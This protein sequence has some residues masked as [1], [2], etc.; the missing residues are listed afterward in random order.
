MKIRRYPPNIFAKNINLA[1]LVDIED[2]EVCQTGIKYPLGSGPRTFT[3]DDLADAV[4]S[5]DDSAVKTPRIKLGH[6][7]GL[8]IMEDGQPAIGTV[9]DM[10]TEQGGHMLMG[11]L[12]Q[13]PEWLS[14]ILP[15]AY[16]ARS[17]EGANEVE[18][19]T[20]NKWRLVITD[21][22][23]L[24]VVWPGVTT[25]ED[26]QALYSKDGPDNVRV[27]T[28]KEEVASLSVAAAAAV[29]AQVNVDD[30]AREWG[31]HK[32]E[33]NNMMW[34]W[35]RAMLMDPNELIV[36]DEDEGELYRIPYTISGEDVAF[37]DPIAVKIQYADKPKKEDKE[38]AS[39]AASAALAGLQTVRPN[40]KVI[41]Q[42]TTREE[43]MRIF[44]S[45]VRSDIDPIALRTAL[46]LEDD[47]TDE[48]VQ[49]ILTASGFITPPGTPAPTG[50]PASEQPGTI[51]A[52]TET[53][54]D[55]TAPA[56]PTDP[57]TAQPTVTPPPAPTGSAPAGTI[58]PPTA[59]PVAA[60]GTV[61][62]DADTYQRL[63]DG[64]QAGMAARTRQQT[65]DRTGIIDAAIRAG[66]IAPSRRDHWVKKFEADE[67]EATTLLTASA[68]KGGLAPGLIPVAPVGGE[69]PLEDT[70]VEAYPK[71]WL[72]DVHNR[73][74]QK[75]GIQS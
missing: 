64:A 44:A 18:T 37:S 69:H 29:T 50:A 27:L 2:V 35:V 71:E 26:I 62:L 56:G 25:L 9:T 70:T 53:T 67:Q 24:G 54:P 33:N 57:A 47:A 45:A 5:Q 31:K 7:A 73:N 43:E 1:E 66:K 72:A 20:G 12:K 15:S 68:D 32:R 55:N 22:A 48:Q 13:V 34:W 39:I 19:V 60:D 41:A 75:G 59:V 3:T 6:E 16:P 65:D 11:T 21:L 17:I 28:T 74:G 14:V 40:Q 4:A 42:Y 8:G 36:E 61:R 23:L 38:A 51:P 10:R 49:E 30:V 46:G 52:G 58:T 63:M